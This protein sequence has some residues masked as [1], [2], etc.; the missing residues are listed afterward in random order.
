MKKFVVL[1][2]AV[3]LASSAAFAQTAPTPPAPVTPNPVVLA[4]G[5]PMAALALVPLVLLAVLGG[6]SDTT[7]GSTS[8]GTTN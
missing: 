3:V 2:T 7:S 5:V 4:G 6:S 1:T 8:A